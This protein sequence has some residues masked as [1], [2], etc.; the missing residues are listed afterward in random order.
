MIVDRPQEKRKVLPKKGFAEVAY[1][2]DVA[3]RLG[4]AFLMHNYRADL[5]KWQTAD[6]IGYPDGWNPLA[7]C[8][9]DVTRNVDFLGGYQIDDIKPAPGF[10]TLPEELVKFTMAGFA[11]RYERR[12]FDLYPGETRSRAFIEGS[13]YLKF[14][15]NLYDEYWGKF[16]DE[17][18]VEIWGLYDCIVSIRKA[19]V[20]SEIA[21]YTGE[22]GEIGGWLGVFLKTNPW[23]DASM[24]VA[25]AVGRLESVMMDEQSVNLGQIY[26]LDSIN[27]NITKTY[28]DFLFRRY[29]QEIIE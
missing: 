5:A 28:D 7:Y 26:R 14:S 2:Y 9:N 13:L 11:V 21:R 8:N 10:N 15:T 27:T 16:R 6:P 25:T 20:L 3:G 29:R 22:I 19:T 24:A 1:A 4:R 12:G 23:Y 18:D 17:E